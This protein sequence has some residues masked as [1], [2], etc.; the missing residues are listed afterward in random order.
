MADFW[1]NIA[2]NQERLTPSEDALVWRLRGE[3]MPWDKIERRIK[4]TR[5]MTGRECFGPEPRTILRACLLCREDFKAKT[6]FQRMCERC[7]KKAA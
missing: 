5:A 6:K 2:T 3:N 1:R 7:R 4:K